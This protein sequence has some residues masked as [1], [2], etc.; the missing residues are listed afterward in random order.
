MT[1]RG[2]VRN[3]VRVLLKY[4][5]NPVTRRLARTSHS[6]FT[7]VR[8]IGRRSGRTYETP[9]MVGPIRH[10]THVWTERRLV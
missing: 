3:G 8:H 5:L 9:I 6:P 10:R 2:K 7:I 1:I 4:T